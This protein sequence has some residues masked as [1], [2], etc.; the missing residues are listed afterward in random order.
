[1][2]FFLRVYNI[3]NLIAR[4]ED[5]VFLVESSSNKISFLKL[6]SFVFLFAHASACMWHYLGSS[7]EDLGRSWIAQ[8]GILDES[9][10]IRYIYSLYYVVVVMNTIGF[11][12][13]VP[14][15]HF[16]KIFSI[17]FI[18]FGCSVFAY[19]INSIG[20]ILQN[21]NKNTREYK[22]K[23]Y[24]INGFMKSKN[25]DFK[26]RSKVRNYLDYIYQEERNTNYEEVN[27]IIGKLSKDLKHELTKASNYEVLQNIPF[28]SKNFSDHSLQK[29]SLEL[30]ELNFTPGDIIFQNYDLSKPAIY[31]IRRGTVELFINNDATDEPLAVLNILGKGQIFGQE[32]VVTG[33]N[34]NFS[35]RSASF[36]TVFVLPQ[37]NLLQ[38]FKKNDYDLETWC[39]IKDEIINNNNREKLYTQCA[40]C[41]SDLHITR[42]CP[43]INVV[44]IKQNIIARFNFSSFQERREIIRRSREKSS[45]A[46][47]NIDYNLEKVEEIQAKFDLSSSKKRLSLS[48]EDFSGPAE[49]FSI[50]SIN[51]SSMEKIDKEKFERE[52]ERKVSTKEAIQIP[53]KK[54]ASNNG[55][56]IHLISSADNFDS[57]K[58]YCFYF[59]KDNAWEFI[60]KY[61]KIQNLKEKEI[62]K[63][64]NIR[65][66]HQRQRKNAGSPKILNRMAQSSN[67]LRKMKMSQANT[68]GKQLSSTSSTRRMKGNKLIEI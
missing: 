25:I 64:N 47:K 68:I 6:I 40:S 21:I 20:I 53:N 46:R 12:D 10:W 26:T 29:I 3:S 7:N 37:E 39:Q 38:I 28:F 54:E 18:Y 22:R 42:E 58:D 36:T 61:T 50:D 62:R 66:S 59:N 35:A 30:K 57:M 15:T 51:E 63:F 14:I 16:E 17:F 52:K 13:I 32:M 1:M 19:I 4:Y 67:S 48:F 34:P 60:E 27:Q 2:T 65:G 9:W 31:I 45:H 5:S 23:M 56:S 41:H 24:L 49:T 11:G 43:L 8:A 44:W 55:S 33:Q